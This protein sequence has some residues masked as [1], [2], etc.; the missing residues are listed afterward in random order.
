MEAEVSLRLSW[1]VAEERGRVDLQLVEVGVRK[2]NSKQPEHVDWGPGL[3]TRRAGR[4]RKRSERIG[5]T[6]SWNGITSR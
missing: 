5:V 6:G 1:I 4:R 2:E 3:K